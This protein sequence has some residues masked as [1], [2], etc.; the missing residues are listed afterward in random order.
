[1]KEQTQWKRTSTQE[2]ADPVEEVTTPEG[3]DPVQEDPERSRPSRRGQRP[4]KE[5]T[6]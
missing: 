2:G 3:A 6:Q 4:I 5:E 1:M